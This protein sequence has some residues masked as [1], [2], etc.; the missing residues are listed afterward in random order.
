MSFKMCCDR[1]WH[2]PVG[3]VVHGRV[4]GGRV[5]SRRV[6]AAEAAAGALAAAAA[7]AKRPLLGL[8]TKV[9]A[10]HEIHGG[11]LIC[12]VCLNNTRTHTRTYTRTMT[13]ARGAAADGLVS[14]RALPPA[15]AA[16]AAKIICISVS[17]SVSAAPVLPRVLLDRVSEPQRSS[18]VQSWGNSTRN[19]GFFII[20]GFLLK[21]G[22]CVQKYDV[23]NYN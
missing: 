15:A 7:A 8:C 14:G 19:F 23:F 4:G 17:V 9:F 5:G 1:E 12:T 3:L 11:A 2:T 22:C 18:I 13:K 21:K 10:E 16:R 6:P 20:S